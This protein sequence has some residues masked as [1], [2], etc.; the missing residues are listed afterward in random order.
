MK[1]FS[2]V[3]FS[4]LLTTVFCKAQ[5][6]VFSIDTNSFMHKEKLHE[7][8]WI[9]NGKPLKYGLPPVKIKP[10]ANKLDTIL[11]KIRPNANWDTIICNIAKPDSLEFV[12]NPC[13]GAFNIR[14]VKTKKFTQAKVV[15]KIKTPS[16]NIYLGVMSEAGVL[17]K[18]NSTDTLKVTCSSVM[19]PNIVNV[20]L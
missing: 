15:F 5:F 17:I 20:R 10:D 11:F 12:Y 13:C 18:N 14:D 4:V 2:I 3:I 6:A 19:S 9:I 16:K 7:M 8:Q 1:N